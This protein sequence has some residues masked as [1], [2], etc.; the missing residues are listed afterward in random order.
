MKIN[1]FNDLREEGIREIVA[2]T[3]DEMQQSIKNGEIDDG[4]TLAAL[5]LYNTYITSR[6]KL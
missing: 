2:L 4:Y 5:T 1:E 6:E 3:P